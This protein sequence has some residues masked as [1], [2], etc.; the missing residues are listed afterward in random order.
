VKSAKRLLRESANRVL[1]GRGLEIVHQRIERSPLRQL[2]LALEHFRIDAVI[3]VGANTGQFATELRGAGFAG[4]IHSIEPLPDA[5]AQL[6]RAADGYA[7]WHVLP[8]VAVGADEQQ[9][10][11]S[12]AG[13]SYSSSVLEMLDR[14]IAAAPDSAP[15]GKLSIAQRPLDWVM[16]G[17]IPAGASTLLKVDT[18]GYEF[19]VL[20]G[21]QEILGTAR[22]VLLEL[23]LQPL[24]R[25][26]KLWLELVAYMN[27][28]G[29]GVWSIQPEFCDP[30]TGQLLQVNGIF[31]RQAAG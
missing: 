23:S 31:F 24:Y 22:L 8:R 13:N 14:H 25:D 21:A 17:R 9:V 26:Q 18:Q 28:R 7:R 20:E 1:A 19:P 3:D 5:H 11:M 16:K 4:D 27:A 6:A 30:N 10:E 29:F 12:I 2:M 15:I